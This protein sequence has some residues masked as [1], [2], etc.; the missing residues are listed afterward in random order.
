[1]IHINQ[2]VTLSFNIQCALYFQMID[3]ADFPKFDV[4]SWDP[5]PPAGINYLCLIPFGSSYKSEYDQSHAGGGKLKVSASHRQQRM[6]EF[7]S[8]R[9][10]GRNMVG[11]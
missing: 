11:R 9:T 4:S 10:T 1:M 6:K 3:N 5:Q 8:G 7:K 2:C